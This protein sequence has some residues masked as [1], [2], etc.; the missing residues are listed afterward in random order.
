MEKY[1]NKK[2]V[3]YDGDC[4]LCNKTVQFILKHE[5][6][7]E[8]YFT[9]LQSNFSKL[10][11]EKQNIKPNFNTFYYWKN[12]VLHSKSSG[13]LELTKELKFPF[14]MLIVFKLK[15]KFMRDFWYDFI[16]KRRSKIVKPYCYIPK[17]ETTK[18]FID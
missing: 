9:A 14:N 3:F 2:I 10:F 6:K 12:N 8:I 15:P 1:L 7:H 16:A 5:K 11:F 4:G 13:A 18:R 17:L